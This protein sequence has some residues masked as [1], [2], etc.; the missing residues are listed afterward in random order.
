MELK[1]VPREDLSDPHLA[2]D[3]GSEHGVQAN[4]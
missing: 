2:G 3:V 1:L 4:L